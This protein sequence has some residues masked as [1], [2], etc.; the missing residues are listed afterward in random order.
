MAGTTRLSR[1]GSR[2]LEG[3]LQSRMLT[4]IGDLVGRVAENRRVNKTHPVAS[5]LV[6]SNSPRSYTRAWIPQYMGSERGGER[7]RC[8]HM[9]LSD[10]HFHGPTCT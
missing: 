8:R 7:K 2:I 5:E 10:Q 6:T 4:E 3:E 1:N 9:M